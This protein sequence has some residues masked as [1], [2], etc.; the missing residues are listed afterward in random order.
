MA[1]T[2]R[3]DDTDPRI[4]YGPRS[5][6]AAVT[7]SGESWNL[8]GTYHRASTPFSQFFLAF[9]GE[10]FSWPFPHIAVDIL[11][12]E[13]GTGIS[14]YGRRGPGG[15]ILNFV[16]DGEISSVYLNSTSPDNNSTRLW[17]KEGLGDGDHQIIGT[18]TA[19]D[20]Q[21]VANIWLDYFE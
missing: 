16:F 7:N 17:S 19:T 5:S 3:L 18:T 10:Y 13:I 8:D 11:T 1:K 15:G 21:A 20:G 2:L 6:W 9:R 12:S 14:L 4:D